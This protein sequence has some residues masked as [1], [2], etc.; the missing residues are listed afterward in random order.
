VPRPKRARTLLEVIDHQGKPAGEGFAAPAWWKSVIP[1]RTTRE[2]APDDVTA[3]ATEATEATA[4]EPRRIHLGPLRISPVSAVVTVGALA[5]AVFIIAQSIALRGREQPQDTLLAEEGSTIDELRRQPPHPNALDVLLARTAD[6]DRPSDANLTPE[7]SGSRLA[8]SPIP[9]DT[10]ESSDGRQPGLNYIVV[11]TF[12]GEDAA[13]NAQN[14]RNFLQDKGIRATIEHIGDHLCLI[15][16]RGFQARDPQMSAYCQ[17]IE[18]L[19][20]AYFAAGGKY[21]FKGCY[22]KLYRSTGW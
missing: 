18:G 21:R 16:L 22:G 10:A 7:A 15:T 4:A 19:G 14:A 12:R 8:S 5:I 9:S 20:Q 6:S 1:R 2:P 13:A 17:R 11:E 3:E